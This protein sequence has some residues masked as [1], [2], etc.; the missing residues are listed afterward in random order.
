MDGTSYHSSG[1][2]LLPDN[3]YPLVPI[4]GQLVRAYHDM[5]S[6]DDIFST[7]IIVLELLKDFLRIWACLIT[8]V[9]STDEDISC[10][11]GPH[12]LP[13]QHYSGAHRS[14]AS[15]F[16]SHHVHPTNASQNILV[17]DTK[18][19][20]GMLAWVISAYKSWKCLY[21]T[22]LSNKVWHIWDVRIRRSVC[23]GHSRN[24]SWRFL[25]SNITCYSNTTVK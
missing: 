15:I 24:V 11:L 1:S 5:F 13:C 16:R 19:F 7:C 25:F 23:F 9:L 22:K 14:T 4:N 8:I 10:Y 17:H 12:C 3:V 2:C 6:S 21:N 20:R 18:S